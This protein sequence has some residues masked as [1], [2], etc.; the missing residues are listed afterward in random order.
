MFI[1]PAAGPLCQ[2]VNFIL[3]LLVKDFAYRLLVSMLTTVL[4][5]TEMASRKQVNN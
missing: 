4:T 1:S 2:F 5:S 3:C